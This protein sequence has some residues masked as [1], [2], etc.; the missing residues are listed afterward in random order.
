VHI[1][2]RFQRIAPISL[3]LQT[4]SPLFH[5]R[6][7]LKMISYPKKLNIV[8]ILRMVDLLPLPIAV[9]VSVDA[10]GAPDLD[11]CVNRSS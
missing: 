3:V 2:F 9:A 11:A 5:W 1:L 6:G 4:T 8:G 7:F 10:D